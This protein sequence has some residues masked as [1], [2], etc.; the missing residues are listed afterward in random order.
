MKK[1][2]FG[3]D[4]RLFPERLRL[5]RKENNETQTALA[6]SLGLSRTAVAN[7]EAGLRVPP[8][9]IF[10]DLTLRYSVSPDFLWGVRN[11]RNNEGLKTESIREVNEY[12]SSFENITT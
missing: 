7:W 11:D 12:V 10:S 4:G 8:L 9:N 3:N 5:L 6:A 2:K 1:L